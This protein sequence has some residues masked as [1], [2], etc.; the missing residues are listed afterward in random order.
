MEAEIL[1]VLKKY[2][3]D[4]PFG[5]NNG[6]VEKRV[7]GRESVHQSITTLPNIT[8]LSHWM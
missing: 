4:S 2:L 8:K 1:C 3:A 7:G 6:G 5:F